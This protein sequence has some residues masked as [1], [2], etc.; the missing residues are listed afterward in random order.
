M[1]QPSINKTASSTIVLL[2]NPS[3]FL[4]KL[5]NIRFSSISRWTISIYRR[6]L[7]LYSIYIYRMY[8]ILCTYRKGYIFNFS[9]LLLLPLSHA[10]PASL[11]SINR[12]FFF[13]PYLRIKYFTC[14][15][16]SWPTYSPHIFF[17]SSLRVN[18]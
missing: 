5:M 8:Q 17:I 10:G 6:I 7:D 18:L 2:T 11:Y 12:I 16:R 9:R 13:A 1:V 15:A 3:Y 14:R 4:N